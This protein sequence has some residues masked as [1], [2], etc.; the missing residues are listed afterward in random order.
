M[1]VSC[2][3]QKLGA[4][5]CRLAGIAYNALFAPHDCVV[6][7]VRP[8]DDES[9]RVFLRLSRT[10]HYGRT[11]KESHKSPSAVS[12]IIQRHETKLG[13]PLFERLGRKVRL[14]EAGRLLA[15][16]LRELPLEVVVGLVRGQP[17][18][19]MFMASLFLTMYRAAARGLFSRVWQEVAASLCLL[20]IWEV[21]QILQ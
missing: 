2:G 8:M 9:L 20:P 18:V 14:T 15:Q 1:L 6:R 7:N 21:V 10:L 16:R 19:N 17:A 12:R 4:A 5:L 13:Q 11:S 3:G